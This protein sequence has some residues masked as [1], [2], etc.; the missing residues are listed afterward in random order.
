MKKVIDL[1]VG[2]W[3]LINNGKCEVHVNAI[4][5]DKVI[6]SKVPFSPYCMSIS[7][8]S[9]KFDDLKNRVELG[10]SL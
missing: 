9:H 4:Q 1:K 10:G 8:Y 3:V 7:F 5:D 2:D 6:V